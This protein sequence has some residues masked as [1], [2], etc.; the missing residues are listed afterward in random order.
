[1]KIKYLIHQ[2]KKIEHIPR[3][4]LLLLLFNVSSKCLVGHSQM[5]MDIAQKLYESGHITYMRTDST[6]ISDE[7]QKKIQTHL[8]S[9]NDDNYYQAP[10][11]KKVKGA[12]EAHEAIRPTTLERKH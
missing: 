7:Y 4:H 10:K 3:N 2:K 8:S 9:A 1:M 11:E 5:T 12:Q 6:F